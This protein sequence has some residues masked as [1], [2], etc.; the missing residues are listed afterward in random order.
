[1]KI[2]IPVLDQ[3]LDSCQNKG[4]IA[5]FE[6]FTESN[7]ETVNHIDVKLFETYRDYKNESRIIS[8]LEYQAIKSYAQF[9]EEGDE[10]EIEDSEEEVEDTEEVVADE[11]EESEESSEEPENNKLADMPEDGEEEEE[12]DEE[13]ED[14]EEDD[15]DDDEEED[16]EDEEVTDESKLVEE[17][18]VKQAEME[19]EKKV[20]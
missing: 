4:E 20:M 7:P 10:D 18:K 2:T 11:P 9:L 17:E 5:L 6:S 3:Y 8:L 19:S 12:D 13:E 16:D 14:E 15:D 1:M